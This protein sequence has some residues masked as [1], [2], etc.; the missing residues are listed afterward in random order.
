MKKIV[1]TFLADKN[2]SH[3]NKKNDIK[4]PKKL[5]VY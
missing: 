4:W 1:Q 3:I 2:S 5:E